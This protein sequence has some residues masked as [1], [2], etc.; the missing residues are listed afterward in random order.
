MVAAD[1]GF[2]FFE[3]ICMFSDKDTVDDARTT[4]AGF[5]V[6]ELKQSLTDTRQCRFVASY[7]DLMILR[8]DRRRCARQHLDRI[9]RIGETLKAAF[10]KWIKNNDRHAAFRTIL[11]RMQHPR[12]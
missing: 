1:V 5:S 9:L 10:A 11:Q 4:R 7:F 2:E 12:R 3:T 6:V 8:T